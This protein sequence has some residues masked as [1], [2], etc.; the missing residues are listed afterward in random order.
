M[1][2]RKVVSVLLVACLAGGALGV[3]AYAESGFKEKVTDVAVTAF[4]GVVSG[5][6]GF[7]SKIIPYRADA[8]DA[9]KGIFYEGTEE[10]LDEPA[11]GAQWELGSAWASLVPDDWKEHTYYLGGYIVA[12]NWFTNKVEGLIDDMRVRVI[13]LSDG[14]GR[15][16]SVFGTIDSIGVS[17][18]DIRAIRALVAQKAAEAGVEL[19]SVNVSSTH[20]HSGIDTQG[21]WTDLFKKA[22]HNV[23]AAYTGLEMDP[24]ADE[25]YLS[26]MR[27]TVA[28]AMLEAIGNMT[29]GT[30]TFS[31]KS[32]SEDYFSNKN[33]KSATSLPTELNRFVFTPDDSGELPT[34][35][36]NLGAHP[37][38]TGLPTDDNSGREVSGD[39]IYWMGDEL[40]AHGYNCM[41]F[42]GAI[43]GIY[44]GRGP[45]NDGLPM[46]KRYMQSERYGREIGKL[47]L[48]MNM[49]EDEIYES[50]LYDADVIAAEKEA[51]AGGYTLWCEGWEPVEEVEV[52][53]L[54]NIR[55]KEVTLR[56]TNPLIILA[57][58][59]KLANYNIFRDEDRNYCI[60]TE[61]GYAEF[62]GIGA[63][64]VPGELVTDLYRGGGSL[65]AEGSANHE[66]FGHP[67]L[68]EIFGD[69]IICFGLTEDAIGYIVP[70]NDYKLAI[71]DDHYQ[72][73]I[74]LGKNTASTLMDAYAKL[75]EE[76]GK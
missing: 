29:P 48:A 47:L 32:I 57:G 73:L 11:P 40:A 44:M 14:S 76:I 36:V 27:E 70:D 66:D 33:R 22:I 38:V 56:A 50:D 60:T 15:G 5:V 71:I 45:S 61:I 28:D 13:A 69:G 8:E 9:D 68:C 20:C 39:Y 58:K 53:P 37:D 26:F 55:L 63:A 64:L 18:K 75:A 17:N 51:S 16:V 6:L 54:F 19:S 43:A 12:D 23:F 4:D 7:L 62:G 30:M 3:S 52:E 59:L 31:S 65:T 42:N 25:H 21:L 74:S 35:I 41:F 24:G 46:E 34:M 67:Y 49:T 10:F 1:K 72:E 2:I